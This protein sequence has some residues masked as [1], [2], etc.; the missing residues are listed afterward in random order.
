MCK[1]LRMMHF[2]T[3]LTKGRR[4]NMAVDT[5]G[6]EKWEYLELLWRR[7]SDSSVLNLPNL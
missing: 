2:I 5:E 4:L 6:K 3:I 1:T 7:Y